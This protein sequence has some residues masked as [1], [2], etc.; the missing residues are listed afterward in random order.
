MGT[1]PRHARVLLSLAGRIVAALFGA[2]LV[3]S[4]ASTTS[5][6]QRTFYLDRLDIG[7]SPNDGFAAWR[8]RMY[9]K[10]V[11][12]GQ[13]ALGYTLNP[14]K[15]STAAY[16]G[17]R[18]ASDA[19]NPVSHQL[20]TY[21]TA[22]TEILG[23]VG[24]A[25]N[26]PITLFETGGDVCD[27]VISATCQTTSL[28]K[29]SPGDIRLDARLLVFRSSD[30]R[31]H[32]GMAGSVYVPSGNR[33]SFTG[34]DLTH[35]ALRGLL[36]V[37]F[38]K[39]FLTFN[40]GVHFR[41]AR[42]L[43]QLRIG[44]EWTW[45]AGGFYPMRDGKIRLG[46]QIF[47]STGIG[48]VDGV[49]TT[50]TKRNTPI[51][52][53]G[54]VRF[55]LDRDKQAWGGFGA[56]TR[57]DAGY[58]APDVRVLA[59]IGYAFS[60]KDTAP[61]SPGQR[62]KFDR[63]KDTDKD[64]LPDDVDLC[65]TVPEDGAEPDPSDGCP[66]PSDR[67][68]DGIPDDTDKCP[69]KP[70][71]KDGIED[72]D[73]C[74][75]DDFDADG[76]PDASDACP[77]EPG[78]PSPDPK[79]NGCPEFIRHVEGSTEIQILKRVEFAT[80]SAKILPRSFPILDEVIKLLQVNKDIVRVS[81]E[82]HTDIRGGHDMNMRLSQSRAESVVSYMSGHGIDGGRLEAHGYGPDRPID[83]N[84]TDEGRQRNRRVEFH[85][86]DQAK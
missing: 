72:L 54:E 73:G 13:A 78:Q 84:D 42:G 20:N 66:A 70:E 80:G 37:D 49:S 22:G 41:P 16:A 2:A 46:L 60:I 47:G 18:R 67:D 69:D 63:T 25:V 86:V 32:F 4:Y 55:A 58:G 7:G 77:R 56:G 53:L 71:D 26:A 31:M 81:V 48:S 34:D 9:E 19:P 28:S 57:L 5:A 75:E 85:I 6:Q 82:G 12:F 21:L 59:N 45:V 61:T 50:F 65:P 1:Q 17:D 14:L 83:T 64:G 68:H 36:E 8:P 11:F 62:Y 23:R 76:I 51:E 35:G 74:P 27:R 33:N 38:T 3:L 79:K 29:A 10:T 39:F 30:D 43:N 40:T 24:L 44:N 52:W 15:G